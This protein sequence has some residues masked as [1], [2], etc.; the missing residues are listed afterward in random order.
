MNTAVRRE[1]FIHFAYWLSFFIFTLIIDKN[2]TLNYW[3]FWF[4]GLVGIFLP[5]IDHLIYILFIKPHELTSLRVMFLTKKKEIAR[6][7]SLLYVTRGERNDLI[8][9]TIFFQ[10]IL[11]VLTF[12]MVSSSGS[13]FGQ[14]LVLSF[15]LHLFV[16]QIIDY[17]ETGSINSWFNL[18]PYKLNPD[19][20]RV[21]ILA[22][23]FI[24][25]VLGLMV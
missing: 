22:S 5:D 7:V 6:A 13:L 19:Q 23:L 12:W 15:A 4:G 20:S 3:L 14:G 9:H 8:F 11:F 25:F 17:E 18:L 24:I 2:L 1:L 21:Y 10:L 16:D